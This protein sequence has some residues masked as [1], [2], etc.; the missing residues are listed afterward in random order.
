MTVITKTGQKRIDKAVDKILLQTNLSYPKD[1]LLNIVKTLD[2]AVK[3][4]DFGKY[5]NEISGV[6]QS[7]PPVIFLNK[8]HSKERQ[9]FTLAHEL[10]HYVLH[11]GNG[12]LRIDKYNYGANT[13]EAKE[14][15]EANYFA[16]SLLMPK[17]EFLLIW[18]RA[19][20]AKEVSQYFGVSESAVVNRN[21]WIKHN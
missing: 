19:E 4:V 11:K 10:G 13:K 1:S 3:S 7:K 14:E 9:T 15:T 18:G 21:R 6:I 8:N 17:D 16:A 5:G 20:T 12:K 2:I